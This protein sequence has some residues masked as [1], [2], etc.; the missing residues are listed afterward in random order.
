MN[1]RSLVYLNI[2]YKKFF[3]EIKGLVS[4]IEGLQIEKRN[5]ICVNDLNILINEKKQY[6]KINI[7]NWTLF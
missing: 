3:R 7:E 4:E 6:W 5:G 1:E 2:D